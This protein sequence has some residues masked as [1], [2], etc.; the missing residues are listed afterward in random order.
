M[1]LP[2]CGHWQ[3][4]VCLVLHWH[5][6]GS[7]FVLPTAQAGNTVCNHSLLS[8]TPPDPPPPL[9]RAPLWSVCR[10]VSTQQ[11]QAQPAES[12][13]VLFVHE[14]QQGGSLVVQIWMQPL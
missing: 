7:S 6:A 14:L 1:M 12:I 2:S 10:P 8:Y 3:Q 4:P 5:A 13:W 9:S 11:G